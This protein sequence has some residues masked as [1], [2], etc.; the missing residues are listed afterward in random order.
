MAPMSAAFDLLQ[1]L[2]K[3]YF[4]V[5]PVLF[6]SRMEVQVLD[7]TPFVCAAIP[8]KSSKI[9]W[10]LGFAIIHANLSTCQTSF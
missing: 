6:W 4:Y 9:E 7:D 5:R 1:K 8:S 2:T 10:N 3:L